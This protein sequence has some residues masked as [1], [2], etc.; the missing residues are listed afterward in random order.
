MGSPDE[1]GDSVLPCCYFP[2]RYVII[3]LLALGMFFAHAMRVNVAV[4]VVT[5]LD[6]A[7]YH[8]VGST[9]AIEN[10]STAGQTN[11]KLLLPLVP[12]TV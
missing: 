11:N 12:N 10:V 5:I 1:A 8:K 6:E 2:R 3:I 7:P 9:E 4:T